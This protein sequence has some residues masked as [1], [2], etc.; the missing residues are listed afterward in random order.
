MD[1]TAPL[2]VTPPRVTAGVWG[3]TAGGRCREHRRGNQSLHHPSL[4][5]SITSFSLF[6]PHHNFMKPQSHVS[7][8]TQKHFILIIQFY[9]NYCPS[10]QV[11]LSSKKHGEQIGINCGWRV[12]FSGGFIRGV[13]LSWTNSWEETV[14][15]FHGMDLSASLVWGKLPQGI[16]V[17]VF[18]PHCW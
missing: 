16:N 13:M 8:N 11:G 12:L 1:V 2:S 14:G 4:L 3:W 17:A 5:S 6:N 10:P 15:C 7:S 18:C 9:T